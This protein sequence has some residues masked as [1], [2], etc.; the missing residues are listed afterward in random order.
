MF[1]FLEWHC[2]FVIL[3]LELYILRSNIFV[4][5]AIGTR[6]SKDPLLA[7]MAS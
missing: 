3:D 7:S 2:S 1:D 4:M 5:L 6:L